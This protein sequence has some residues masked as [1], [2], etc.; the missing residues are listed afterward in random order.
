MTVQNVELLVE[1]RV[2]GRTLS[3]WKNVELLEERRVVGRKSSCWKNIEL[4]EEHRVVGR[5]LS[6]WNNIE[7][8]EEHRVVGRTSSCWKN[9]ELLEEHRV[10]G[11]TS[12]CW[13]NIELLEAS[14]TPGKQFHTTFVGS[15]IT[16]KTTQLLSVLCAV[17][18]VAVSISC[19][20]DTCADDE[21]CASDT[22]C[23]CNNSLYS[24]TGATPNV[25]YTCTGVMFNIQVSKCWLEAHGYNP[26]DIRLSSTDPE[27]WA[28]RE[29]VNGISEMTLHRPLTASDCN[30]DAVMNSSHVTYT[31]LLYI[32]AKKNP[33]QIRDDFVMNISC[34]EPLNAD[35]NVTLG[36]EEKN[37][38]T[39]DGSYTV[40]MTA[41]KDNQFITQ[42][43]DSDILHV[44]D[45]IYISVLIP[46]LDTT[47]FHLK[48]A[49]IYA[50]PNESSSIKY[51]LLQDGCPSSNISAG[52][53]TVDS[54]GVGTESR[55]SLKVFKISSSYSVYLYAEVVLCISN[56]ITNCSSQSRSKIIQPI[57]GRA[58]IFLDAA[59]YDYNFGTRSASGFSMPWTLSA[60]IFSWILMKLM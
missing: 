34:S 24:D 58:S 9:I 14:C 21:L 1:R 59:N 25:N 41:Y 55:F 49:S 5:T 17:M 31:N 7:L 54:N 46:D 3:C 44:G 51:Y 4:L 16:M 10:V 30:T 48:V 22:T 29:V 53:L 60:L 8:L 11:R 26:S 28:G 38:L 43:S 40:Y 15:L 45:T 20:S 32:F 57:A 19:G 50:S 56:C 39:A 47:A 13:K 36:P 12:S 6:S 35:P 42:L 33:I 52:D 23:Q 37:G 18:A 2:V 27:C